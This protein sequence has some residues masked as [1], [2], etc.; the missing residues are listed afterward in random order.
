MRIFIESHLVSFPENIAYRRDRPRARTCESEKAQS[1]EFWRRLVALRQRRSK[2]T[3]GAAVAVNNLGV[4]LVEQ[5]GRDSVF[6]AEGR[7]LL[8]VACASYIGNTHM[9]VDEI[10]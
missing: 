4:L 5:T 2:G 6:A 9:V 8:K 3:P 1:Q 10:L 7:N